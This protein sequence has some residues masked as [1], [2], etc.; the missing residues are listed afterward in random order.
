MEDVKPDAGCFKVVVS[1]CTI[2]TIEGLRV[3]EI[4]ECVEKKIFGMELQLGWR[5]SSLRGQSAHRTLEPAT[6]G[7]EVQVAAKK[8]APLFGS[9]I[10]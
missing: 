4:L 7:G 5:Q 8:C 3:G 2:Q 1:R 10:C 9:K 6:A